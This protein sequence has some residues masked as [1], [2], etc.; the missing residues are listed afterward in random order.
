MPLLQKL[1][2]ALQFLLLFKSGDSASS[3]TW[4]KQI[5]CRITTQSLEK[6]SSVLMYHLAEG[7]DD[8]RQLANIAIIQ[9]RGRP[10]TVCSGDVS[11]TR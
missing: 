10:T 1:P 9:C 2:V 4:H 6:S 5:P 8:D 3:G 7:I 11:S